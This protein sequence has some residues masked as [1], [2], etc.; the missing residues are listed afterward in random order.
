[1]KSAD[2][3]PEM[4]TDPQG[5]RR[6]RMT[7]VVKEKTLTPAEKKKREEIARAMERENPSMPMA[8]K[9]AIATATAKKVAEATNDFSDRYNAA[10]KK[11]QK[12]KKGSQ[13]SFTHATTGKKVTGSY[14]GLRNMG[15]KSY[16]HV[17]HGD[18]A[19]RV[20]VHQIHQVQESAQLGEDAWEEIPMM[21]RQLHFI[22]Y[23]AEEML[24]YMD[25]VI[26]PEEWFQNKL[27][28]AH[29]TIRSLHSYIEG[30]KRAMG[31]DNMD[32]E[33]EEDYDD[34][35]MNEA[36]RTV[37]IDTPDRL[38][39][40]R[41]SKDKPPFTGGQKR[42]D[43][44]TDKSGAKH[45]PMSRAKDLAQLGKKKAMKKDM[46]TEIDEAANPYAN[47]GR[48]LADYA[49]KHGGSDKADFDKASKFM[50]QI[51]KADI[52][53]K[54]QHLSQFSKFFRNLDTDVRDG[55]VQILKKQ[56]V[57]E[58]IEEAANKV[59][60]KGFGPD[61]A[62]GN[63]GN[64]MARAALGKRMADN[65]KAR[66]ALKDPSHNPAWANSKSKVE[67]TEMDRLK[68]ATSGSKT[69]QDYMKKKVDQRAAM[70][71]ANDPKA[72]KTGYGPAV[73]P[74]GTA[75]MKARKKGMSPSQAANAVSN[76]MKNKGKK[77]NLPK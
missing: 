51:G 67:A 27:A 71:K 11:L 28:H 41:V 34:D 3:K 65:E 56:N 64:P 8:K 15:G 39:S 17:E 9:M 5:K 13:V 1:M 52:L 19:T 46:T 16:A 14:E 23:A 68:F 6:V 21:K 35:D 30:D 48:A 54:G 61:A 47:A 63:M 77:G 75:Y 20:P 60:L 69:V 38:T 49:R 76:A 10:K 4:Y 53:S 32:D 73:I 72:A 44:V 31:W 40:L 26:D 7:P 58:S 25:L 66:Q 57:M 37:T 22:K 59:K 74:P 33:D 24:E 12:M 43:T 62:K 55:I 42:Q 36:K 50:Y 18:G 29:D 70:N 45:T 2:R